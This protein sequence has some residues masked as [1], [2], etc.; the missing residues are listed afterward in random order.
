MLLRVPATLASGGEC[1]IAKMTLDLLAGTVRVERWEPKPD[2]GAH[3]PQAQ[4]R[5][6][7]NWRAWSRIPGG[8]REGGK[9]SLRR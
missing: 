3:G 5:E 2:V 8:H 9:L 6:Q 1:N 4:A 7:R